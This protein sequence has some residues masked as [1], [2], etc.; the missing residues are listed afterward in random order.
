VGEKNMKYLY[1]TLL[2]ALISVSFVN[3]EEQKAHLFILSGQ[4]NMERLDLQKSLI[5]TLTKEL[6][7]GNVLIVKDARDGQP[8]FRWYKNWKSVDGSSP[9]ETGDVY[10]DLMAKVNAVVNKGRQIKT[11]TFIWMQGEGDAIAG[12]GAVYE[13]SLKGLINQLRTDMKRQDIN[14]IIGRL[15]DYLMDH[16]GWL[17]VRLAQVN[18]AESD[19]RGAW[20]DTDS[21]NGEVDDLHYS[22]EGYVELGRRFAKKAITLINTHSNNIEK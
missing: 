21:L 17:A 1:I 15:S 20:V 3:A 5:P 18:V 19:P 14:F 11:V 13:K 22:D 6:G 7:A 10:D 9:K 2:A 4:S 8:I 12:Q 16:P